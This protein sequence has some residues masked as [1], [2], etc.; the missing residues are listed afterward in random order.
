MHVKI[1]YTPRP[2]QA[3]LHKELDRYRFAVLSCHRRFGK[4]VAIINHLIKAALTNK[5]KN[6]RFAYIAPTYKQAK[7][8]AWDYMKMF[9]GGIPGVRF[10]ETELRCDLPNGSRIT[11]LSSEQPDSLRGLFLDGVCIDE[12]AQIDPRL[13]NEIIRPALSDRKGFCYFIGTPAGMSNIFYELYQH[14]LSDDKWLAYTAKASETKVIDQEELDAAKAQMGESKY[15][16]EFECDWIANIEGA[17]YGEIIKNLEEKKQLTRVGYD[18]ALVVNTAWD[19]GV[20]DSTAIIFFQQLGNQIM[21]I[22]YYENNREG[23]PHYVQ[24]IKDKDYVYG[25]HFAPHDIEVTEFSSGKTRRE[26][27]YQLGVRFKILPKIPLEDGIHSLKMVLPKCWFDIESTKPLINAL[28]HHHR[29]Y[30]EKMKMFS[31]KPVKDWSSHAC[32]SARYMALAITE[33]PREKVAAQKTAVNDYLIH[34][35]I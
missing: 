32:D 2:L 28:R 9:A 19:I 27:A 7:S 16:Q 8:I 4:S 34:G 31:N 15:K 21:V 35:E 5:L 30:N 6:P 25:E 18:P 10:H 33:L 13:W 11:L 17:I 14:A 26:V 29:K 23:L 22:D 12:V 20:D 1:P 3:K 24:M